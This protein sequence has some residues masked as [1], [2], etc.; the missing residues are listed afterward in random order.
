MSEIENS[1]IPENSKGVTVEPSP[2]NGIKFVIMMIIISIPTAWIVAH[3]IAHSNLLESMVLFIYSSG[4]ALGIIVWI[5]RILAK[6]SN[7]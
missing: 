4:I 5:R 7:D 6:R 3:R 1:T 2:F